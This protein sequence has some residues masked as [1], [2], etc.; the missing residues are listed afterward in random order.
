MH[1]GSSWTYKGKELPFISVK[2]ASFISFMKD[3]TIPLLIKA[4][5]SYKAMYSEAVQKAKDLPSKT[6]SVANTKANILLLAGE[7]DQLWD[8]H[9]MARSIKD[10][11]PENIMIQTYPGAGHTLQGLQY[12]DAGAMIIAF[13]GEEE[14]NQKAK[15]ESQTL[16][17]ETL[18]LWHPNV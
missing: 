3:M 18:M 11:R 8:S 9:T 2:K 1:Y 4:P 10:Q 6:I 7:A 12:V 13:G 15:A 14:G 17:L 16:I 5:I